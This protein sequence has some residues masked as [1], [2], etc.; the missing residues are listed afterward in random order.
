MSREKNIDLPSFTALIKSFK[1]SF[2][3][4]R[5][6]LNLEAF[7]LCSARRHAPLML[8]TRRFIHGGGLAAAGQGLDDLKGA[9]VSRVVA[10]Q[11]KNLAA[12][13]GNTKDQAGQVAVKPDE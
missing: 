2:G 4:L 6:H 3:V 10:H 1:S 11:S 12:S 5:P 13:E 7:R 8:R 9:T